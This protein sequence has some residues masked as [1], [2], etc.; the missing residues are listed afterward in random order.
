MTIRAAG[1]A[2]E[3]AVHTYRLSPD[4]LSEYN[5]FAV[6]VWRRHGGDEELGSIRVRT[7]IRLVAHQWLS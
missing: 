7:S 6:Q 2:T 4:N 1:E 3:G 5:V